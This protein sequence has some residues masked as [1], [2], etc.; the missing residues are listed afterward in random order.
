MDTGQQ[1]SRLSFRRR[2]AISAHPAGDGTGGGTVR[3][4]LEDDFHH[5]RVAVRHEHGVVIAVEGFALRNPYSACPAAAGQLQSLAGMRLDS[6][7]NSVTRATDPGWQCTHML[8]LAGL[9]IA[10]AAR[11]I[12]QRRYDIE[13]PRPINDRTRGRLLRDGVPL[14]DWEVEGA[15]IVAPAPYAGVN[16]RAGLARWALTT[17]DEDLAEATLVLRRCVV[18]ARGRDRNLDLVLHA[19]PTGNCYAQQPAQAPQALR[20]VDSTFDFTARAQALCA[21]DARWLAFEE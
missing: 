12:A 16:L 4:A 11:G 17:L 8:D 10:A 5:F 3:A 6:V 7:A 9:A 15:V 14:L 2:I 18:I 21:I 19:S 13:V 1:I 20:I